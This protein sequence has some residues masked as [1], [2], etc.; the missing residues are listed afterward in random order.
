ME[1]L[2][3]LALLVNVVFITYNITKKK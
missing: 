2:T 3:L 1:I